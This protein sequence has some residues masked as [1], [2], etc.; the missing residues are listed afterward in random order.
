MEIGLG[1]WWVWM[2]WLRV[3][4]GGNCCCFSGWRWWVGWKL[5]RK[6]GR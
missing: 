1:S 4:I 6:F 2:V 5:C 3:L